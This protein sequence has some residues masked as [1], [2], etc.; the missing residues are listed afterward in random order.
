MNDHTGMSGGLTIGLDLGDD[1]SVLHVIDQQGKKISEGRVRTREVDLREQFESLESS[2]VVIETG[3]HSPWVSRVLDEC[4]HEVVVANARRVEAITKNSKKTDE[5][6]AELLARLGR[7]D[8]DLLSP[9]HHRTRQAQVDLAT[10]RSRDVLVGC[11][12]KLIASVR[13]QMKS[14]G[15]RLKSCS[16]ASFHRQT[17]EQVPEEL[18]PAL[19]PLFEQIGQLTEQIR[20]YDRRIEAMCKNR[21]PETELLRQV[22]GVGAITALCFVLTIEVPT[23]FSKSRTVGAFLGLSPKRKQSGNSDP[24]LRIS[25]EGDCMLRRLL[26]GSARYILGPFGVDTDLKRFGERLAGRGGKAARSKAAVAVA[27][28][29]SVLLVAL[30]KTAEVYQPL[31]NANLQEA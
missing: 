7:V 23:R 6:D 28:K 2:R 10:I 27:R 16:T 12:T 9:V 26:V 29:L 25:K 8:P 24:Q 3:T 21:Y 17:R 19:A 31:R 4:G 22:R 11:R 14:L 15:H 13:G 20:E 1:C 18:R 5:Q 30:W